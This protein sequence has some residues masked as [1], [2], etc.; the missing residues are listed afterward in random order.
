MTREGFVAK[1]DR[2]RTLEEVREDHLRY[3]N[4][5]MMLLDLIEDFAR[6]RGELLINLQRA[7]ND[8]QRRLRPV[9]RRPSPRASKRHADDDIVVLQTAIARLDQRMLVLMGEARQIQDAVTA[10]LR[11][12]VEKKTPLRQVEKTQHSLPRQLVDLVESVASKLVGLC[13]EGLLGGRH[14]V[15]ELILKLATPASDPGVEVYVMKAIERGLAKKAVRPV[16]GIAKI[17]DEFRQLREDH[18]KPT[19]A[20]ERLTRWLRAG[21]AGDLEGALL[22]HPVVTEFEEKWAVMLNLDISGRGEVTISSIVDDYFP[23]AIQWLSIDEVRRVLR[24]LH[25]LQDRYLLVDRR[26]SYRNYKGALNAVLDSAS[27]A[28]R[29]PYTLEPGDDAV[30]AIIVQRCANQSKPDYRGAVAE[31]EPYLATARG[32]SSPQGRRTPRPIGDSGQVMR[33]WETKLEEVRRRWA[34]LKRVLL[35]DA[36]TRAALRPKPIGHQRA[37]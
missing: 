26:A 17:V 15:R 6:D 1:R 5:R 4:H 18:R 33:R 29:S 36:K 2:L 35:L 32:L 8:H 21:T 13:D 14:G 27:I 23:V 12:F 19:E 22:L 28:K 9:K 24:R 31:I 25:R 10:R 11:T 37:G 34:R 16:S 3:A 20:Y 30:D 7:A